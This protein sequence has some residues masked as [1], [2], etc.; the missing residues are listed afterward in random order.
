MAW[1]AHV[2]RLS[3]QVLSAAVSGHLHLQVTSAV[4][5]QLGQV[6]PSDVLHASRSLFPGVGQPQGWLAVLTG[7][8]PVRS[9]SIFLE[10]SLP[11]DRNFSLQ[12]VLLEVFIFMEYTEKIAL[13][14]LADSD[15]RS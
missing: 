6:R 15:R 2:G 8:L 4:Q 11:L 13:P 3:H 10:V 1:S 7:A 9:K 14:E 12:N 5:V